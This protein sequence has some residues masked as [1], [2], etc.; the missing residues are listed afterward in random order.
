MGTFKVCNREYPWRTT[1]FP[2]RIFLIFSS[3][4]K[5]SGTDSGQVRKWRKRGLDEDEK[6]YFRI[7]EGTSPQGGNDPAKGNIARYEA[8]PIASH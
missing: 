1:I 2:W 4:A 5:G 7:S 6:G 3:Q 8:S